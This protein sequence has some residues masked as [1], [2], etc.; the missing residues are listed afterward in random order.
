M[1]VTN[2][3]LTG[4]IHQVK[5]T[6]WE[7]LPANL[8]SYMIHVVDFE[9]FFSIGLENNPAPRWLRKHHFGWCFVDHIWKKMSFIFINPSWRDMILQA[10]LVMYIAHPA[11]FTWHFLEGLKFKVATQE[12]EPAGN[13]GFSLKE[14]MRR[15]QFIKSQHITHLLKILMLS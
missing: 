4:M 11:T 7:F 10:T 2:H 13:A 12:S 1:E 5:M 8:G 14:I 15:L 6:C 3:L 9:W